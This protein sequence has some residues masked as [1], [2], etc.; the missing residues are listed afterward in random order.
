M[1]LQANVML[2][3]SADHTSQLQLDNQLALTHENTG[4]VRDVLTGTYYHCV[5]SIERQNLLEFS[6][7]VSLVDLFDKYDFCRVKAGANIRL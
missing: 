1:M 2:L 6:A 4:V 5:D 3:T 7:P